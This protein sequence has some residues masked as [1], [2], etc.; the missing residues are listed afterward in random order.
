MFFETIIRF[1][2]YIFDSF[3]VGQSFHSE[4]VLSLYLSVCIDAD[5]CPVLLRVLETFLSLLLDRLISGLGQ[6]LHGGHN[7]ATL[8]HQMSLNKK[9]NI[10]CFENGA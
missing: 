6:Q 10:Y 2:A 9:K 8:C 4:D 5:Q 1:K 7:R 3:T